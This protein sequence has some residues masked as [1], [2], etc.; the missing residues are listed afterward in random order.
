MGGTMLSVLSCV[1]VLIFFAIIG[2]PTLGLFF[3]FWDKVNDREVTLESA[4]NR[5][6]T[7]AYPKRKR[8]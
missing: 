2:P 3:W 8:L 5:G 1:L 4:I 7:V 6:Y